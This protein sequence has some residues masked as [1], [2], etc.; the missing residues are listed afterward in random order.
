MS[1]ITIHDSGEGA[2]RLRVD[3]YDNGTAYN[4]SFGEAGSPMRNI[5]FHG[6]HATALRETFDAIE[7]INPDKPTR[8]VWF[9]ALDPY[10]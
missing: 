3:S 9:D 10:L 5:Y 1:H 7:A 6:D 2:E 8:D 4:V